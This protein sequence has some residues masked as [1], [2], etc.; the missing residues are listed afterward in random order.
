MTTTPNMMRPM[1]AGKV[2]ISTSK[3]SHLNKSQNKGIGYY[4]ES[5]LKDDFTMLSA[6]L[7]H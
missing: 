2:S 6:M 5:N 7:K 1:T 3:K 4:E